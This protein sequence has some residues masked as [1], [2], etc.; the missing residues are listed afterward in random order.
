M[1][2]IN[3]GKDN[4]DQR[5]ECTRVSS[6]WVA[7]GQMIRKWKEGGGSQAVFKV[8]DPNDK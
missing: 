8:N 2:K 3:K 1:E 4:R 5:A 7:E 6:L